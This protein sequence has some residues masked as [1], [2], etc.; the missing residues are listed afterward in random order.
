MKSTI[1]SS[2][3]KSTTVSSVVTS[4]TV[5]SV[6]TSTTVSSVVTS[7]TVSSVVTSTTVSIIVKSTTVSS[8]VT[9][10]TV[11]SIVS[12]LQCPVLS[13]SDCQQVEHGPHRPDDVLPR[14]SGQH[15]GVAGPTGQVREQD[16]DPYQDWT[17]LKDAQSFPPGR[18]LHAEGAGRTGHA[19]YGSRAHPT[20]GSTMVEADRRRDHAFPI[21]N[22]SRRGSADP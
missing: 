8:V 18:L 19:Q 7:T 17:Q 15:A 2:V 5:S 9:S 13:L 14:G 6:V 1:V 3:M 4:T 11:S 22:E 12:P 20:V 10:T 16:P 21:R